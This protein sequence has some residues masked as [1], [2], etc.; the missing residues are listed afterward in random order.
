MR[1]HALEKGF[2]I[3]EYK[4]RPLGV[5]GEIQ[6]RGESWIRVTAKGQSCGVAG[7]PLPVDSEKDV[8]D[9]IQW[10][11]REPKDRSE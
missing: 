3:N 2:T 6:Q 1:A 9:Y 7:E 11:Y 4:I 10:K 8:F 5:T